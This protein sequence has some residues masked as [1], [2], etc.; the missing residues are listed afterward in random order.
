MLKINNHAPVVGRKKQPIFLSTATNQ[1]KMNNTLSVK[2]AQAIIDSYRKEI[3]IACDVKGL[4]LLY[5]TNNRYAPFAVLTPN[6]KKTI[7]DTLEE[8]VKE[9]N[10]ELKRLYPEIYILILEHEDSHEEVLSVHSCLN[11]AK[12]KMDELTDNNPRR[13]YMIKK[14]ILQ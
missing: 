13:V 3:I 12:N 7:F 14:E 10:D 1:T 5:R 6:D 11:V 4:R 8:A 2:V 9:F